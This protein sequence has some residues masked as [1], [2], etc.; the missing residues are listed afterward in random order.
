MRQLQMLDEARRL[1]VVGMGQHELLVLR[2]RLDLFL[3]LGC[4]QRAVDQRH[5]HGF[6]FAMAEAKPVAAREPRRPVSEP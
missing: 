3:Q 2:G 6:A 4:A 5:R 1:H